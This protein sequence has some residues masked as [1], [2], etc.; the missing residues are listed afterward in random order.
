ALAEERARREAST[1]AELAEEQ[2]RREALEAKE[3]T[4]LAKAK[5]ARADG[6]AYERELVFECFRHVPLDV[7]KNQH[8]AQ[9]ELG[10][11]ADAIDLHL[12]RSRDRERR[13]VAT[14]RKLFLKLEAK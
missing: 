13:R 14:F 2:A 8:K 3:L 11:I 4:R 7:L 5:K 1:A 9:K 12:G 6:V 10:K